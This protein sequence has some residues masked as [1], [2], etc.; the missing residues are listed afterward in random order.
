M[1]QIDLEKF[2]HILAHKYKGA[3]ICFSVGALSA[4]SMAPANLWP[5]LFISLPVLYLAILNAQTLRGAFA[6][7]WLFGFGYFVF[8]LSWIG[9]AL[10]VDGNPYMWA[11]PLAVTGLPALL[12]FFPALACLVAK[13]F[14]NL[15]NA[16]GV[17]GFS[18][19]YSL[20]EILRGHIFTGFP[21]NLFGYTWT[22]MLPILQILRFSDVYFL[23]WL[24]IFW[25]LTPLIFVFSK[26]MKHYAIVS[27]IL[28]TVCILG[29]LWTLKTLTEE[30]DAVQ[31]VL[32]QPNIDQASKWDGDKLYA[33]FEKHIALSKP[34]NVIDR[35]TL[36]I[37]PE[38][39]LSYRVFE[40]PQAKAAIR[41]L[42]GRYPNGS[43]L[44]TGML[45]YDRESSTYANAMVEI[46]ANANIVNSYSKH[47]LVPFGEYIPFQEYIPLKPV[48]AFQGFKKG[49][50][51]KDLKTVS[52]QSITPLIC[53][54]ILF[55]GK[56]TSFD[57]KNSDMIINVTND[58]WYGNSAGPYQHLTKTVYRAVETGLPVVRAANTGISAIISANGNIESD[59]DLFTDEQVVRVISAKR[60]SHGFY[61]QQKYRISALFIVLL[62]FVAF[63]KNRTN[64]NID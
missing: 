54:E 38:T 14:F 9:N 39:A 11:W 31:I 56:I 13:R 20:F 10:L 12:A 61:N 43:S 55:A 34:D 29:G 60:E 23:T 4:F 63:F 57:A 26:S 24:T 32:V 53:Y 18:A 49:E 62:S 44:I 19:I 42:L 58:A 28:F 47:H 59:T 5:V 7:G 48:A 30:N 37:W 21:W 16:W 41:K 8:S 51:V 50:G 40:L 25:A 35:P 27:I 52:G 17:V 46:D 45:R 2:H 33:H 36:I 3:I 6:R 15:R 1:F 64:T 22:D